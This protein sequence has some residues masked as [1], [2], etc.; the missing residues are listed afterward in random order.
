MNNLI[1]CLLIL[2]CLC[3]SNLVKAKEYSL[4]F[5]VDDNMVNAYSRTTDYFHGEM[6]RWINEVNDYYIN[7]NVDLK[8]KVANVFFGDYSSGGSVRNPS[9][10]LNDMV[11][12]R[13]AFIDLDNNADRF[14]ADY[15]VGVFLTLT[16]VC[17]KASSVNGGL[18]AN[19][20]QTVLRFHCDSD[21]L[22]HE[23]GH[24]MGLAHGNQ[25]ATCLNNTAHRNGSVT[26]YAKGYAVTNCDGNLATDEF[27]TLMVHNYMYNSN[28]ENSTANNV[29]M[30]SNA[31]ISRSSC[32]DGACGSATTGDASRALNIYK[33]TYASYESPDVDTL[34][35]SG[36][37]L[38]SCISNKYS[39]IEISQLVTLSCSN[40]LISDLGGITQLT[41]MSIIDLS[42]NNINAVHQLGRLNNSTVATVN[43]LGNDAAICSQLDA[44][45]TKFPGKI[46]RPSKCLNMGALVATLALLM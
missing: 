6:V 29:F 3:F 14:G 15:S 36:N 5:Y 8:V 32:G 12:S 40:S 24:L 35:Y 7:S 41:S 16:G 43:L 4:N 34:N 19:S 25:V 38:T 28:M 20:L 44:L 33:N 1:K 27:G 42:N 10:L 9:T 45:D 23:L 39:G 11:A 31:N 18:N 17:G 22:A 26:S 30:F 46:Q 13:N 21:T 37:N 2:L